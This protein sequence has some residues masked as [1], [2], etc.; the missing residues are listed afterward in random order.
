MWKVMF[1]MMNMMVIPTNAPPPIFGGTFEI[2]AIGWSSV[3]SKGAVWVHSISPEM[4]LR[5]LIVPGK[6]CRGSAVYDV[7]N[8]HID[9][10]TTTHF[11]R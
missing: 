5:Q 4:K 7:F 9:T 3:C 10:C 1:F 6:K 11:G 2:T 8:G